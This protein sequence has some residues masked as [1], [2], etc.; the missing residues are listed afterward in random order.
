MPGTCPGSHVFF[1]YIWGRGEK[2]ACVSG[3][4]LLSQALL[5]R[6]VWILS[7]VRGWII[8]RKTVV[9][10]YHERTPLFIFMHQT[11]RD[12][13]AIGVL[14]QFLV[15]G[16]RLSASSL[17]FF[18][19]HT[20]AYKW[21]LRSY[22]L[23][24]KISKTLLRLFIYVATTEELLFAIIISSGLLGLLESRSIYFYPYLFIFPFRIFC[25]IFVTSL[26]KNTQK[27]TQERERERERDRNRDR[28]R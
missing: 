5:S 19:R 18:T 28:E 26:I 9:Y 16:Q 1:F 20:R 23:Q 6:W 8:A 13:R 22:S 2:R 11:R 14:S 4:A 27:E 15:S 3:R 25:Y 12:L 21:R 10:G 24:N 17:F 7:W